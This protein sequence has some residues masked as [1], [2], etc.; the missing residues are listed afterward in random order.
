VTGVTGVTGVTAPAASGPPVETVTMEAVLTGRSF[1]LHWRELNDS[2]RWLQ[3][4]R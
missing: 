1:P 3:G 4:W 2:S